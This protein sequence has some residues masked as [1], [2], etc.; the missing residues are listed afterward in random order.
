MARNVASPGDETWTAAAEVYA[1]LADDAAVIESLD[2]AVR[3]KEPTAAYVLANPLFAY[4]ASD[5]RFQA[6]RAKLIAQ[7]E[8]IRVALAAMD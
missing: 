4:L 5:E 1:I 3:R 7:Q 8:E 6:I 2:Q